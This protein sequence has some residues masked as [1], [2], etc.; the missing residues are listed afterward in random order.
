[1]RD[2]M[3][4][5][6]LPGGGRA[7]PLCWRH[8]AA[9][10]GGAPAR[11]VDAGRPGRRGR[12]SVCRAASRARCRAGTAGA[13]RRAGVLQRYGVSDDDAFAVGLACGGSWT[14][15]WRRS[16]RDLP[17]ARGVA[18]ALREGSPVAV[19]TVV[20]GPP[21]RLESRVIVWPTAS[22]A[23][24]DRPGSTTRSTMTPRLLEGGAT[25]PCPTASTGNAA[26][27]PRRLR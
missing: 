17:P 2:V 5:L 27:R 23:A 18:E 8:V 22:R 19:A 25:P 21:G 7:R 11:R 24:P 13:P 9:T 3:E 1:M 16:T 15:S 26:A 14:S 4:K 12:G 10:F 20:G 6:C